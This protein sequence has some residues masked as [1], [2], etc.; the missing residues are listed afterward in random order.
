MVID[1]VT[2][3]FGIVLI[4][5]GVAGS[6][7][8]LPPDHDLRHQRG[9][10]HR[11]G[12]AALQATGRSALSEKQLL[13][14]HLSYIRRVLGAGTAT[15]PE[16][17]DRR[18]ELLG[19][20]DDYI[21]RGVTPRNLRLP[22]RNPVF[23]DDD[24][25]ICA[26]GYLIERSVG[27]VLAERVARTHRFAYLAEIAK[28]HPE[29]RAWIA[30]SGFSLGELASIQ[31]GYMEP[32]T[33]EWVPWREHESDGEPIDDGPYAQA[34]VTGR[35]VHGLMQ[36]EWSRRRKGVVVGRGTFTDGYGRWRSQY[37]SG[38]RL[39]MGRF[40]R[41]KPHGVW[42]FYHRSGVLAARGRFRRGLRHGRWHFYYDRR[43]RRLISSGRFSR[44]STVGKWRHYDQRGALVAVSR[45]RSRG[46]WNLGLAFLLDIRPGANGVR[47]QVHQ[48]SA[49]AEH[50]RLDM[51]VSRD[52]RERLYVDIFGNRIWDARGNRLVVTESKQGHH[53]WTA[54][55]CPWMPR[56]RRLARRGDLVGVHGALRADSNEECGAAT[57]VAPRRAGRLTRLTSAMRAIRA[58]APGFVRRLAVG[59]DAGEESDTFKDAP[60]AVRGLYENPGGAD[61]AKLLAA[62]MTWYIEWPHVDGRFI[63]VL[64]TVPGYDTVGFDEEAKEQGDKA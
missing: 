11:V 27:R 50:H 21:A 20:L 9:A 18:R 48:G 36:G 31:P 13:R 28:A 57:R 38:E 17:A 44:G 55:V 45:A 49:T 58:Q 52:R 23:I 46:G 4:S 39:A 8:A 29:V 62:H 61:L 32:M 43:P 51:I 47:H 41:N 64:R 59:E 3:A 14:A 54:A 35:F 60:A 15:R 26:V 34:G 6:V 63:Q 37:P 7:Q 16:L 25:R 5:L 22:W 42:R 53:V 10:N 2:G 30:A 24:G 56:L 40:S 1:R 19:Y 33:E 12:N